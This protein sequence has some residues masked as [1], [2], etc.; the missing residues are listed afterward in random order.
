VG[1]ATTKEGHLLASMMEKKLVK[2]NFL[3]HF[4]SRNYSFF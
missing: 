1:V 2:E 3:S 4:F